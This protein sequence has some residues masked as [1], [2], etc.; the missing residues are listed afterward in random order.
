MR[1]YLP[2]IMEYVGES[3]EVCEN[4]YYEDIVLR[5]LG[6][7]GYEVSIVDVWVSDS[8]VVIDLE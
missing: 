8:F 6:D 1:L 4:E 2:K 5:V 3:N 7:R